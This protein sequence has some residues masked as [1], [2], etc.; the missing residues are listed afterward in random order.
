MPYT[1]FTGFKNV[2]WAGDN[3]PNK[4]HDYVRLPKS[5]NPTYDATELAYRVKN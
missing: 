1:L 2:G 5:G 3:Q 4:T